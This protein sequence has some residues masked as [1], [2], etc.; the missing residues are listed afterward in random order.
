M[1]CCGRTIVVERTESA[2]GMSARTPPGASIP[3]APAVRLW[4]REI[5]ESVLVELRLIREKW[6]ARIGIG[7][8]LCAEHAA[9]L[10][11]LI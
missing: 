7:D 11:I 3:A 1:D 10:S 5:E 2:T 6:H 9:N 4:V 8:T